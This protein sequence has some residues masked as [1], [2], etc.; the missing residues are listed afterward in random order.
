[1]DL[2][3]HSRPQMVLQDQQAQHYFG[4]EIR[5]AA[6]TTVGMALRQSLADRG[7]DLVIREDCIGVQHPCI[8]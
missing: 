3:D 7:N 1:V 4:V 8:T 6:T 5:P 2:L